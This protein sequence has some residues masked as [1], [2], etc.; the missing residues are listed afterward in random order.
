MKTAVRLA[1]RPMLLGSVVAVMVWFVAFP[2]LAT[3]QGSQGQ[4]AVYNSIN[5]VVGSSSFIDASMFV[6]S[7]STLCSTIYR[8][9]T[10]TIPPYPSAGAVIDAR[11]LN[12]GNTNMTCAPGWTPWNNG[13]TFQNKPSAILLPAGTIVIPTTWVL[14]SNTRLVGEGEN[15]PLSSTPGTTIQVNNSMVLLSTVIQFGS[16]STTVCPPPWNVVC[17]ISVE[18]LTLDGRAQSVHG[19][20]NQ[21]SQT[22]TY[23]DHVTLYQILG[24]GL[25]ISGV[26]ATN[27]GPY[28]NITFDTG[29]YSGTSSTVCA[30][31]RDQPNHWIDSS[32]RCPAQALLGW[33]FVGRDECEPLVEFPVVLAAAVQCDSISTAPSAPGRS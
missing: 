1:L 33:G 3:A 2:T 7:G 29:G 24:T 21:F 23:V 27:S 26:G 10:S 20:V 15:N 14:P 25:L 8:V 12:A 31:G 28:T 22:N 30:G 32:V 18:Q 4:D 13:T 19:I 6:F 5:G 17:G 9:L 11:G 16:S